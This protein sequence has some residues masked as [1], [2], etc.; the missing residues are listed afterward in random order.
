MFCMLGGIFAFRW[1]S[2]S[3]AGRGVVKHKHFS[4]APRGIIVQGINPPVPGTKETKKRTYC[5]NK[6]KTA[7][8]S[9]GRSRFVPGTLA[10]ISIFCVSYI[11]LLEG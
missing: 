5:A 10:N 3:V 6:Q 4:D 9:Q 2:Y 1:L 8:L 7:S 11:N